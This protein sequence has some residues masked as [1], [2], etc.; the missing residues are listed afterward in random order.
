[1]GL[2]ISW[3]T[4][5]LHVLYDSSS[6]ANGSGNEIHMQWSCTP[7]ILS[8]FHCGANACQR[9]H[10]HEY[11]LHYTVNQ[12]RQKVH[13]EPQRNAADTAAKR[14]SLLLLGFFLFFDRL[15]LLGKL[16]RFYQC[17]PGSSQPV[18]LR[19]YG[20]CGNGVQLQ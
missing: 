6:I 10:A 5:S 9:V 12:A 17:L 15:R 19:Q 7:G 13:C 2:R 20:A 1:M 4:A 8:A 14:D 11:L 16:V 18:V 3:S